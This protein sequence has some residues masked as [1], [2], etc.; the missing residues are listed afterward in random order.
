MA[1]SDSI[2]TTAGLTPEFRQRVIEALR[3]GENLPSEWA[4]ELFPPEKREYE[5]VYSQ[6]EREEDILAGTMAVPLQAVRTFGK[7]GSHWQNSLIFGDNLQSMKTLLK[8]KEEGQLTNADGTPGVRLIYIDPPFA[9]KMEFKGTQDQKAYQDKIA[10]ARFIEFLRKRLVLMRDL[11][12]TDGTIYV[13]M[14]L[15]TVHY[16]KVV[17]DELFGEHNFLCEIIWKSTSAHSD[18]KRVGAIHQTILVYTRGPEWI[19][20]TQY[21][22]YSDDYKEKYYRY[23]DPDGRQWKSTDLTGPGGRGPVYVWK[24]VKRAWRVTV[25]NMRKYEAESRL[26]YTRNGIPRLKQYWDEIVHRGG[27]PAQS[28]WDDKEVQ[29]WSA[30]PTRVWGTRPKSQKDYWRELSNSLQIPETWSSTLSR[31]Q[32]LP[33]PSQ[34]NFAVDGLESIAESF[35]FT[36]CRNGSSI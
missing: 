1:S 34:R 20:N 15:R 8:V 21:V 19:W 25:E 10:G 9:T 4:R 27:I 31:V 22:P 7:N 23:K 5:L 11:L 24:G 6:K 12:S 32:A 26:F 18:A 2:H 14:D 29:R 30:G 36:Q 33:A 28:L 16:M 17:L 13:H 35:R 3:R